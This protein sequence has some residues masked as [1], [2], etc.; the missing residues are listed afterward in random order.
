MLISDK[1]KH[2]GKF[3]IVNKNKLSLHKYI[4]AILH[5]LINITLVVCVN[6]ISEFV[7]HAADFILKFIVTDDDWFVINN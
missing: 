4:A 5:S 6:A 3:W 1:S 2:N 7:Q